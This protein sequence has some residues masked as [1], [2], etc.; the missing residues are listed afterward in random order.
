VRSAPGACDRVGTSGTFGGQWAPRYLDVDGWILTV[1]KTM[2][3][4]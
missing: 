3:S 2:Y 1:K 4:I